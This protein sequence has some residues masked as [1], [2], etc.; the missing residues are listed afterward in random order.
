MR[1][2]PRLGPAMEF[3]DQ[4]LPADEE[5]PRKQQHTAHPIWQRICQEQPQSMM[6]EPT[7]RR[8]LCQCRRLQP[9]SLLT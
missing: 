1:S 4:T 7:L 3:I 9:A 8:Y 6:G 2:K 5:A